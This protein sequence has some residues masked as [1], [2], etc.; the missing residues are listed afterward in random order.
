MDINTAKNIF[1]L[2]KEKLIAWAIYFHFV[3]VVDKEI[4]K[5]IERKTYKWD[6]IESEI[7]NAWNF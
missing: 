5:N 6:K 7:S 3:F 4:K 1:S 2:K